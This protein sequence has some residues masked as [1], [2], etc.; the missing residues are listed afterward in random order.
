MIHKSVLVFIDLSTNDLVLPF[1]C[2]AFCRLCHFDQHHFL[3]DYRDSIA[4]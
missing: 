2:L 4:N 3:S 1:S